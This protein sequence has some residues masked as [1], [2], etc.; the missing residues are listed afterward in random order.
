LES[1]GRDL[2]VEISRLK[3]PGWNLQS[4]GVKAKQHFAR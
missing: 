3:S 2:L 4:S 1:P